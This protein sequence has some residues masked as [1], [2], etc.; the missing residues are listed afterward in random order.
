MTI[1]KIKKYLRSVNVKYAKKD[2][3]TIQ[4]LCNKNFWLL[5]YS[6]RIYYHNLGNFY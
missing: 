4:E 3:L 1:T 2:L 6:A 5:S